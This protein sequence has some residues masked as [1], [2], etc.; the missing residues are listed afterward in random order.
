[1]GHAAAAIPTVVPT[2]AAA[3]AHGVAGDAVGRPG[4]LF[5]L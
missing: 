4:A 5:R 1:M 2:A 3:T